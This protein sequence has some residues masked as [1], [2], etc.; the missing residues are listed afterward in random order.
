[1][2]A[3]LVPGVVPWGRFLSHNQALPRCRCPDL[4]G[5]KHSLLLR[6]ASQ[7][8]FSEDVLEEWQGWRQEL[9]GDVH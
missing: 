4:H 2:K 9:G 7:G 3:D 6:M 1:M 8:E 5:E